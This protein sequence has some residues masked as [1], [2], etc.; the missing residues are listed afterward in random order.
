VQNFALRVAIMSYYSYSLCS[1]ADSTWTPIHH[2]QNSTQSVLLLFHL[3]FLWSSLQELQDHSST[4]ATRSQFY[5]SYKI[6]V[7]QELQDHS[8]AFEHTCKN[9]HCCYVYCVSTAFIA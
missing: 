1:H 2:V 8:V 7:L 6:T 5:K 9:N 4:R 3:V